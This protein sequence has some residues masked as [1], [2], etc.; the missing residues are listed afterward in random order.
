MRSGAKGTTSGR[1]SRD[2]QCNKNTGA[3]PLMSENAFHPD[4]RR[5]AQMLP[6]AAVGPRTLRPMRFATGLLA[7]LPAKDVVV[8]QVGAIS[9][10]IYAPPSSEKPVAALLCIHGGGYVM[11]TAATDDVVC[12]YLAKTVGILVAS[13]EYRLAPQHRFP[14]PLHDCHDALAWL[15]RQPNVDP[16]RIAV[17]GASA[18]GGLAAALALLARERDEVGLAFQLLSYPMLDDRTATRN[19]LDQGNLRM[20]NNKANRFGW[21]SYTGLPPGSPEVSGLAAPARHDDLAGL[22]EAWIG[23][24]TLDLFYDEDVD[25]AA[26]LRDAGVRCH[27]EVVPGAFHGFDSIQPKAGVTLEFR[28]AQ[29]SAL[30]GALQ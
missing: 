12:R 6:R 15:A 10:R 17:G 13:V 21:E 5:I 1:E 18:G 20:W 24:G 2:G 8:H 16:A 4:L 27:L 28:A 25:Y 9:V 30:A 19:D 26:R 14:Q 7:K 11:G 22:P 29:A 23:V 3:A